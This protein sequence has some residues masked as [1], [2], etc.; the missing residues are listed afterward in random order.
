LEAVNVAFAS[1]NDMQGL[2]E[3]PHLRRV[4]VDTPNGPVS[5]P[6]PAALFDGA[7]RS[8]GAV[9]ALAPIKDTQDER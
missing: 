7:A 4:T 1:V 9:P 2:S 3:H 5:Y 8:F 6:A